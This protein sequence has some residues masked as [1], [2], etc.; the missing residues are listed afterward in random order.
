MPVKCKE[1][2]KVYGYKNGWVF[3]HVR[4]ESHHKFKEIDQ[5]EYEAKRSI[6]KIKESK[7]ESEGIYDYLEEDYF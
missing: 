1:C 5:D 7:E 6:K 4:K 2:E 3:R